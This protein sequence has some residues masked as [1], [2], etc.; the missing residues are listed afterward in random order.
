MT[1]EPL[2]QDAQSVLDQLAGSMTPSDRE[3]TAAFDRLADAL[4]AEASAPSAWTRVSILLQGL[5]RH[6]WR[7]AIPLV[8]IAAAIFVIRAL[9]GNEMRENGLLSDARSKLAEER[10]R[11]AYEVLQTHADEFKGRRAAEERTPLVLDALCGMGQ[12]AQADAYLARF[13]EF[14]PDSDL[15][16]RT[17]D[18]CPLGTEPARR[19]PDR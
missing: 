13:L 6:V 14:A 19:L 18:V 5:G 2:S 3:E 8:V 11:G 12:R 17:R 16:D 15:A 10:Y 9:S 1:D 4:A 7:V